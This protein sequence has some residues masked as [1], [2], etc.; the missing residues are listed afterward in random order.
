[1]T[2]PLRPLPSGAPAPRRRLRLQTVLLAVAGVVAINLLVAA[3]I[4]G[5]S[6]DGPELPSTIESVIPTPGAGIL[7]QDD[8]GADLLD[9]YTG[10]LLIDGVEL[11]EDQLRINLP[12]GE[13][14][15]RPGPGKDITRLE[16]GLHSATIV[17][18]PQDRS[19][20]V[21]K[22]FTWQFRAH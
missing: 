3:T 8:V 16:E 6:E 17:Y 4:I 7:A 21:A 19:R 10:V 14:G 1:M 5:G 12:L 20:E 18:W 15:F 2:A 22:S 13:V 11:P 9:T